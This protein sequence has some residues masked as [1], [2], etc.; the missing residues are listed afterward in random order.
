M[1]QRRHAE[2]QPK[3][4]F[5]LRPSPT[6]WGGCAYPGSNGGP[7]KEQPRRER[8]R[9]WDWIQRLERGA[10]VEREMRRE[11]GKRGEMPLH[12]SCYLGM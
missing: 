11:K 9:F 4:N 2:R 7:L 8:L 6:I 3:E 5:F 12:G 1:R 10:P